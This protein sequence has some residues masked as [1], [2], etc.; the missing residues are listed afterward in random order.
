MTTTRDLLEFW[1]KCANLHIHPDDEPALQESDHEFRLDALVG[2]WMGPIRTAPVVLLTLNPGFSG[3]EMAEAKDP[4]VREAMACNLGGEA[5]LP[6]FATNPG[7]RKW[8]ER[9]LSR[10]DL[11]YQ[12]A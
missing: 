1:A 7:G 8:T 10:L 6:T 2:P 11:S 5:P 12:T 4:A 9:I 3:V